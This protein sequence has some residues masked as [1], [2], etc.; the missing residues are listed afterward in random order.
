MTELELRY[1]D[2]I[3]GELRESLEERI[4]EEWDRRAWEF[5]QWL[6]EYSDLSVGTRVSYIK[7]VTTLLQ[8]HGCIEDV[9]KKELD[10][11]ETSAYNKYAEYLEDTDKNS[12]LG[13]GNA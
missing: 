10:S 9:P 2:E 11:R 8:R 13:E 6:R 7:R 3:S 5:H 1:A 12:K 4:D